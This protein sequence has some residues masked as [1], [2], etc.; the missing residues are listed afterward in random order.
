MFKFIFAFLSLLTVSTAVYPAGTIIAV[1]VLGMTAGAFATV[2]VAFAINMVVSAVISKA[3][4]SPNQSADGLSG[5]SPDVGNRQQVPPATD[6]KLPVVYGEAWVGG[7]I[8]DLSITENNQEL[9]YVLAISEVTNTPSSAPDTITFGDIYWGGKKVTFRSDGFT[10]ASLTDESSGV[11]DTTVDGRIAIYLYSNG[12]NT[13]FNSSQSAI[14]VMQASD[15][16]YKW[17]STKLMSNTTFAIVKLTYSQTANIR[18]IE[19]TRFQIFNSRSETG[20]VFTP[21]DALSSRSN[22]VP[23]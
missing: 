2:A 8:V 5:S 19:Q 1:S 17:D 15:L 9:Y 20:A 23:N 11:V 12:S 14:S 21:I 7:T 16:T 22:P 18:G 10:V 6:N 13:P 3:F 4:F